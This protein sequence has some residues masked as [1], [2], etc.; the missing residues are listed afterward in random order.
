MEQ[1]VLLFVS[2]IRIAVDVMPFIRV[3]WGRFR[4]TFNHRTKYSIHV[5]VYWMVF[6]D[7]F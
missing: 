7:E 5:D 2:F 3:I 4:I 1:V 6:F